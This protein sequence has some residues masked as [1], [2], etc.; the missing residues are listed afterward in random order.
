MFWGSIFTTGFVYV[1]DLIFKKFDGINIGII[2]NAVF[3]ALLIGFASA[4]LFLVDASSGGTDI[5]A[6]IVRKFSDI[7]IGKA[8]FIT[9]IIIVILSILVYGLYLG[10]IS[11][12]AFIVKV[13]VITFSEKCLKARMSLLIKKRK[14]TTA[15]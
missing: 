8:L 12:I 5:L 9:D 11:I 3:G 7:N 14:E 13:S 4:V 15:L 2:Y 1:F 10:L 6:L